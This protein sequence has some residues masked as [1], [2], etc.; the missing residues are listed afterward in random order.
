VR[1]AH[2]EER[3]ALREFGDVYRHYMAVTPGWIPRFGLVRVP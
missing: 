1:L 3:E 2:Q